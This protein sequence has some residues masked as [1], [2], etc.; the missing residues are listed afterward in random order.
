MATSVMVFLL[1]PLPVTHILVVGWVMLS[2]T[3]KRTPCF[4]MD[5]QSA[6]PGSIRG[7]MSGGMRVPTKIPLP[8][9]GK[10]T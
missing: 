1:L 5:N 4:V 10:R 2:E 6:I 7:E 3:A 9:P 8:L